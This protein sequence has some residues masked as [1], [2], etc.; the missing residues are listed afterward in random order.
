MTSARTPP[1]QASQIT[2]CKTGS[3]NLNCS[4][5]QRCPARLALVQ[6]DGTRRH[7][8]HRPRAIKALLW[9]ICKTALVMVVVALGAIALHQL[10]QGGDGHQQQTQGD[11]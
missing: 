2:A 8:R 1:G 5:G 3:C 10:K 9:A 4:Q 7:G 11:S 6:L